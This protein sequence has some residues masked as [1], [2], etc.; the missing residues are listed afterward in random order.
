MAISTFAFPS[1]FL[2]VMVSCRAIISFLE[3]KDPFSWKGYLL[4]LALLPTSMGATTALQH[5]FQIADITSLRIRAALVA[6]VYQKVI[7]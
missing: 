6:A 4:A 7:L 1:L 2:V 5:H 3:S